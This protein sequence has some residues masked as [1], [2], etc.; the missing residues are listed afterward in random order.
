M[1]IG[2][3]V[4]TCLATLVMPQ[5]CRAEQIWLSG[6]DPVVAADR[7]A[8]SKAA[9]PAPAND[10]M[11]LFKPDAPWRTAARSTGIFKI[12]TQFLHRASD[13]ELTAMIAGLRQRHIALAMEAEILTTSPRCGNGVPGYTT[14]AVIQ[15]A[16]QRVAQLGG[17]IDYVAFD[18]PMTWGHFAQRGAACR[19]TT[20]EVVRNIAPNVA[21]LKTMFPGVRFG[22]IEPVTDQTATRLDDILA[23]ARLFE[24]LTGERLSFLHADL[25]WQNDWRPQLIA[26]KARLRAAGIAYGVIIDGDP[27]D[28]TDVAWTTNAIARYRMLASDP[29]TKPDAFVVQSW[30]PRPT[31]LLPEDRQGTLTSVL[32]QTVAH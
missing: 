3:M 18:E 30:Q 2:A 5:V 14:A 8:S 19:Y 4:L 15:K 11:E 9:A 16:A 25:I 26:W 20:E 13:A 1:R 17:R 6:V 29:A 12:S 32:V 21:M 7:A 22:D 23:F 27:S 24:Q 31:R 10:F 28:K